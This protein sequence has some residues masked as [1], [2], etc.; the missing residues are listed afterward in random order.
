MVRWKSRGRSTQADYIYTW[1]GGLKEISGR[2]KV[3]KMTGDS[4]HAVW[5]RDSGTEEKTGGRDE[6][7]EGLLEKSGDS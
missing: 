5:F 2:G 6:D 3:E 1:R 4:G 7:A